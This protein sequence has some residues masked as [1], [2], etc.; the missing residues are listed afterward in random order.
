MTAPDRNRAR[1]RVIR[2]ALLLA[3][4]LPPARAAAQRPVD[5]DARVPP[6]MPHATRWPQTTAI[7]TLGAD[8][9]VAPAVIE[10]TSDG[11]VVF[12]PIDAWTESDQ[13]G[14]RMRLRARPAEVARW[15]DAVRARVRPGADS[16]A[17]SPEL[18]RL[19]RGRVRLA[20]PAATRDPAGR[21]AL[22]LHDCGESRRSYALAPPA[23][24]RVAARLEEAARV[25]AAEV[26][27]PLPPTLDRPYLASEVNC[28][29]VQQF[30]AEAPRYPVGVPA[31]ERVHAE[32]AV[33]VVVDTSGFVEPGS[34]AL[35]P[36]TPPHLG[37]A[38]RA[39]VR[40]WRFQPAEWGSAP[41]RQVITR[42]L[43][44]DP[45]QPPPPAAAPLADGTPARRATGIRADPDGWV[46]VRTGE[47][48]EDGTFHGSQEWFT[49]DS[50]DVWL[51]RARA[52]LAAD[53]ARSKPA[54]PRLDGTSLL[55][56]EPAGPGS[57]YRVHRELA[58]G[59]DS[60][61]SVLVASLDG[62]GTG[63]I[64]PGR[65]DARTLAAFADASRDARAQR[66]TPAPPAARGYV[67]SELACGAYLPPVRARVT[68]AVTVWR[69]PAGAYPAAM[70]ASQARAEVVA[71][72]T[73]DT[74]GAADPASMVVIPGADPRA[75]AALRATL[76]VYHFQPAARGGVRVPARVVR[77][78]AFVPPPVCDDEEASPHCARVYRRGP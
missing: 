65:F 25:A 35:L 61:R 43:A 59:P 63:M 68:E 24:L 48:R 71:A 55:T 73:V 30:G 11:W 62:C 2:A 56:L 27:R 67:A 64:N 33:R 77:T 19:G 45:D 26:R 44:F 57:R 16:A 13:T 69:P 78:W 32:V 72:V 12:T 66:A 51:H 34:V 39:T 40:G 60:L 3:A 46:H 29:A 70:A 54:P 20:G 47:W 36:G 76:G 50:V 75:V 21:V 6:L 49:P 8:A 17:T 42:V 5:S 1:R 28:P 18:P 58:G 41:V 52:V 15:V 7:A 4:G 10:A 53:S 31:A 23:L 37:R 22:E 38:V 14:P 9:Q 74:T